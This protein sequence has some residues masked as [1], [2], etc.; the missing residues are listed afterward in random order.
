MK[1]GIVLIFP[2]NENAFDVAKYVDLFSKN[3]KLH[4]C[5]VH[6]GSSDD[7]LSSLKEIQEEVNCQISIVEIKKNRGHAAA[8]KAGIR[9]L[10]SAA[11]VTHV[12]CVQEFTYATIKNLLHVIHQDK[13]QLKHFFTNLK[14]LPY[15]NVFLLENIGKSVQKNLNSQY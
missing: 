12:I 3:T 1:I 9:Y 4:L 14:R 6:N 7:T 11:N 8:I 5:F 13:K 15:K 10:H 2:T